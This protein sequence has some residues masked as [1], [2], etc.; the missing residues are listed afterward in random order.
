MIATNVG[1][2]SASGNAP[3]LR[4][5]HIP[6]RVT[7][8]TLHG[9]NA[10]CVMCPLSLP[11]KRKK[12]KMSMDLFTKIVNDLEPHRNH[13]TMID[14]F[15]LGE[16]LLDPLIFDRIRLLKKYRFTGIGFSTN[17]DL[18]DHDKAEEV[19]FSGLD[20]I[21]ISIDGVRKETH[22]AIRKN[23]SFERVINNTLHFLSI[24]RDI[25]KGPRVVIRF[26]RQDSN[27]DEWDSFRSFWHQHLDHGMKDLITAYDVH[28]HGGEI[29]VN[30]ESASSRNRLEHIERQCC[31]QLFD[32][33]YV[34]N[35]GTVPLCSE[36]WYRAQ[37]DAGNARYT[38]VIELFNSPVRMRVRDLHMRGDKSKIKKCRKCTVHYSAMTKETYS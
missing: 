3:L 6:S 9:C 11:P 33:L 13:L 26:I 17:A 20:N 38:N 30:E 25:R 32:I 21:I 22:E 35:D 14:L 31:D 23:T 27:R 8:E 4:E 28:T 15:G 5:W 16:P 19:I 24:R 37:F 7:I 34:L 36:D 18:L 10:K 2:F 12:G 1:E 29:A